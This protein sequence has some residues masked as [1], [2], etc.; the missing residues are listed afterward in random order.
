MPTAGKRPGRI[1]MNK[2]IATGASVTEKHCLEHRLIVYR[3]ADGFAQP[4][5]RQRWLARI[6]I[7]LRGF[8]PGAFDHLQAGLAT[9]LGDEFRG[10]IA[11][12][13]INLPGL[14]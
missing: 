12:D 7:Q 8:E 14:Q 2:P 5:I 4:G 3:Q 6:E 1:R 9:E 10:H 13:E 11:G